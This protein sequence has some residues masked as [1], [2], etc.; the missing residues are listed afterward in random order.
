MTWEPAEASWHPET[1]WYGEDSSW[2]EG[3]CQDPYGEMIEDFLAEPKDGEQIAMEIQTAYLAG[4][5]SGEITIAYK[6]PGKGPSKEKEKGSKA[7][8][9][10]NP[11][12][13]CTAK[14]TV[15]KDTERKG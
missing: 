5:E 3:P 2:N 1:A 8:A 9:L 4:V 10:A 7:K 13:R 6:G 14:N 12:A 11:K 15:A